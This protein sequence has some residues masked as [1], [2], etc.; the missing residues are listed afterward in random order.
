MD[1]LVRPSSPSQMQPRVGVETIICQYTA[2]NNRVIIKDNVRYSSGQEREI[3]VY[4]EE[5]EH[6]IRELQKAKSALSTFVFA[7]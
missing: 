5:L 7:N 2:G 6:L 1:G 3:I 4:E